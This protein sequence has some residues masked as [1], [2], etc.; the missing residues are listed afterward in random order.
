MDAH[1]IQSELD[2]SYTTITPGIKKKF[3]IHD[4]HVKYK[5]GTNEPFSICIKCG[6]RRNVVFAESGDVKFTLPASKRSDFKTFLDHFAEMQQSPNWNSITYKGWG[7]PGRSSPREGY[8]KS[9]Y[10]LGCINLEGHHYD[11]LSRGKYYISR[12]QR[13]CYRPDCIDCHLKWMYRESDHAAKRLEKYEKLSKKKA[14]HIIVSPPE[15][16]LSEPLEKLRKQAIKILKEVKA[17]GGII[18]IHPFKTNHDTGY[19]YDSPHFHVIGFGWLESLAEAYQK[20]GWQVIPKGPRDSTFATV[21]YQLSHAGIRKG[22]H[23]LVWF[24]SLSY[25]VLK[26][27]SEKK[28]E[29]C[30]VCREKLMQLT[31]FFKGKPP[32]PDAKI[33]MFVDPEGWNIVKT[34]PRSE[35]TKQECYDYALNFDLLSANTGVSFT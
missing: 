4:Y 15:W 30:P 32:P 35:M 26:I 24:G 10:T 6:N 28:D 7:L 12:K 20:N 34:R 14:K 8:C 17:D 2:L 23:T 19:L 11:P 25:S 31:F 27:E 21:L 33:S 16:V 29:V 18:I 5:Q 13:Y 3:C 1:H 9:W 22:K